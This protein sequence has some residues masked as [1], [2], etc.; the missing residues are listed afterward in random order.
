MSRIAGPEDMA[1]A[2][3]PDLRTALAVM[4]CA[5]DSAKQ[6]AIQIGTAVVVI[7]DGQ[8]VRVTAEQ[9]CGECQ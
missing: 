8:L 1:L 2:R 7:K 6:L 3:N 9:L 4:Q 5:T